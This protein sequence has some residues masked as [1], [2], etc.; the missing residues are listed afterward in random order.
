MKFG[1]FLRNDSA[2]AGRRCYAARKAPEVLIM[3]A[4]QS[5]FELLFVCAYAFSFFAGIHKGGQR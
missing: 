5:V 3:E 2:S 4:D 1:A